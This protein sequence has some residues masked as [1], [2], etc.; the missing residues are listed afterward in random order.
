MTFFECEPQSKPS[1]I[2]DYISSLEDKYTFPTREFLSNTFSGYPLATI[3]VGV[4]AVLSLASVVISVALAVF[5]IWLT[6]ATCV[7]AL[8]A[9]LIALISLTLCLAVILSLV[10][11]SSVVLTLLTTAALR[12]RPQMMRF[13]A[14]I[15]SPFPTKDTRPQPTQVPLT[16]PQLST[17]LQRGRW[18]PRLSV[19]LLVPVVTRLH[20]PR[21]M[22]YHPIYRT[23]LGSHFLGP[24]PWRPPQLIVHSNAASAYHRGA[25]AYP[26][27]LAYAQERREPFP[28]GKTILRMPVGLSGW[29]T[30]LL[31][32][33]VLLVMSPRL[34]AAS[35]RGVL[36]VSTVVGIGLGNLAHCAPVYVWKACAAAPFAA[37]QTPA[38]VLAVLPAL[39]ILEGT[40]VELAP[41]ATIYGQESTGVSDFDS[42]PREDCGRY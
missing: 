37:A 6:L 36:R 28:L 23:L 4:F 26:A 29:K 31:V 11:L 14:K 27:A 32:C 5:T 8:I 24:R 35:R 15:P 12:L 10:L 18:K 38:T 17:P 2:R 3:T 41:T 33:A 40:S 19:A 30:P 20:L 25:S 13:W 39:R 34:R 16:T 7:V 1:R 42:S 21:V 22:R 9:C